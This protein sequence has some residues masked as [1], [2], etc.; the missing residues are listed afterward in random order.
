MVVYFLN[1]TSIQCNPKYNFNWHPCN[2]C[3]VDGC[4]F[5]LKICVYNGTNGCNFCCVDGY[6]HWHVDLLFFVWKIIHSCATLESFWTSST[7]CVE[8]GWIVHIIFGTCFNCFGDIYRLSFVVVHNTSQI[9]WN[10][11]D[12]P[13]FCFIWCA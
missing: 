4:N 7:F 11:H 6:W 13:F 12:N 1:T 5:L 8:F 2:L 9:V 10:V 3:S